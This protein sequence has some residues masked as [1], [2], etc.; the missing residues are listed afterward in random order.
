MSRP[1][2]PCS[3]CPKWEA[4]YCPVYAKRM[5]PLHPSCEY[6]R[7]V[8]NSRK[9]TEFNRKTYGWKARAPRKDQKVRRIPLPTQT[10][11]G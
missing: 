10:D 7:R 4:G 11:L 9:A 2:R 5:A 8:M 1:P 6:G 3:K